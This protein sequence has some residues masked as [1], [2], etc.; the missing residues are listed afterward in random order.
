M[1]QTEWMLEQIRN[2]EYATGADFSKHKGD[3][4]LS[5]VDMELFADAM[6][7]V[8]LRAGYGAGDGT[9]HKDAKFDANYAIVENY[10]K[11]HKLAVGV[12]WY[13]S[14]NSDWDDQLKSFYE[15]IGD[16]KIDFFN[17]DFEPAYNTKGQKFANMAESFM[18]QLLH[19][20][21]PKRSLLYA[22]KYTYKDWLSP[23]TDYFDGVPLW[24]AQYPWS[25]WLSGLTDYF[26]NWW[27][28]LFGDG[29]RSP[30][31]PPSRGADD[32]EIWQV[33]AS[34]GIGNELGFASD[35]LDFN[36]TRRTK[37]DFYEWLGIT[38]EPEPPPEEITLAQR[39]KIAEE[40]IASVRLELE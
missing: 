7:F 24:I 22:G 39:L 18:K 11:E 2:S 9:I 6:D 17:L 1:N 23:Y 33:V 3:W 34:S 36:I 37:V 28:D 40:L 31:L 27:S 30:A 21:A 8:I 26:K 20:Q 10:R 25:N 16:K 15:Y 5:Y 12:Y 38:D 29:A 14:S 35:S 19:D 32:W 4:D 13:F